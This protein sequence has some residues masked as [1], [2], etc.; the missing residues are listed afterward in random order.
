MTSATVELLTAEV[1]VLNI[2]S[3]QVTLSVA[4]QLD[5]VPLS[6]LTVFGRVKLGDDNLVIGADS[7]GRLA[8][9]EYKFHLERSPVW[10]DGTMLSGVRALPTVCKVLLAGSRF[11]SLRLTFH[12]VALDVESSAV[13]PCADEDHRGIYGKQCETWSPGDC[14]PNIE[15]AIRAHRE[16]AAL[17]KAAA[18]APLIVL[19]GLK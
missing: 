2:G 1:R 6:D 9:A 19:A 7:S 18:A 8:L 4:R 3:R 17:H 16:R 11:G 14:G 13:E 12:G 10:I 5:W 15:A